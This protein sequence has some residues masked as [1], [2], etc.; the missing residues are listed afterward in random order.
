MAS[1]VLLA[2]AAATAAAAAS[3]P[4]GTLFGFAI[5]SIADDDHE[6]ATTMTFNPAT[7]ASK[8]SPGPPFSFAASDQS[9]LDCFL[10]FDDSSA[11]YYSTSGPQPD[12]L[13]VD[14]ATGNVTASVALPFS[15]FVLAFTWDQARK[16]AVALLGNYTGTQVPY[17]AYVNPS[18]GA[19]TPINTT[20]TLLHGV[21]PC[22]ARVWPSHGWLLLLAPNT[23][24]DDGPQTW[25]VADYTAG[26]RTVFEGPWSFDQHGRVNS[27]AVLPASFG[28]GYDGGVLATAKFDD[29]VSPSLV[30][31]NFT[32]G[33]P[34]ANL[35]TWTFPASAGYTDVTCT[36]GSLTLAYDAGTGVY[37]AYQIARDMGSQIPLLLSV[38]LK[39]TPGG[40]APLAAVPGSATY[41]VVDET[42]VAGDVYGLRWAPAAAA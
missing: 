8:F 29:D 19:V 24:R 6:K 23:D 28:A 36:L 7:G 4:T 32:T 1:R 9:S 18:S 42:G 30:W 5:V 38:Q 11:T 27:F 25:V 22:E 31:V 34:V 16:T 39:P 33:A 35:T 41:V 14:A 21:N 37:T 3:A 40:A 12:I 2:A 17:L 13:T 20:S 26:G 10:G 15:A